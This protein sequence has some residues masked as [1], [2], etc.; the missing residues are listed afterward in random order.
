MSIHKLIFTSYQNVT[1]C[2]VCPLHLV[3]MYSIW[4]RPM[5]VVYP[6]SSWIPSTRTKTPKQCWIATAPVK[7]IF[8]PSCRGGEYFSRFERAR[9]HKICPCTKDP[10]LW[11][12][13]PSWCFR[14]VQACRLEQDFAVH[15][16]RCDSTR[17][18]EQWAMCAK[19][20]T[21]FVEG[22][23][24]V[25]VVCSLVPWL[26]PCICRILTAAVQ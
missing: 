7:W 1:V 21:V 23:P 9:C 22:M 8:T 2:S 10:R 24:A 11:R 3:S 14:H 26:V 6:W 4:T 19:K 20:V 12:S 5:A 13:T 25:T 16:W 15:F 17:Q 18:I